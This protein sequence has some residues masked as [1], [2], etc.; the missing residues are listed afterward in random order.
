[1]AE[2]PE[3]T[4][5]VT[6]QNEMGFHVRPVQR[7]ASLARLFDSEV[8]VSIGERT[9][10]GKSVINLVSL[11]GRYGD[12]LRIV[13]RGPDAAQ[14]AGVLQYLAENRF[15]VEDRVEVK[16][17]PNRHLERLA[18][19]ASL[20]RSEIKVTVDGR[21]VDAKD[22]DALL[23]LGLSP[24]DSP[25]FCVSG[26]DAEQARALLDNLAA[27]CFYVEDQMARRPRTKAK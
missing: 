2:S 3:Q 23:E 17:R 20:F 6:I 7:F 24:T 25:Q 5:E 22:V 16:S 1:M 14:C 4:A 12:T 9:V 27:S 15:F 18:R 11:G 26:E 10:P 19:L 8:E 21:T 13:V